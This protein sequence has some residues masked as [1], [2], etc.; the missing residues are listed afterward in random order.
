VNSLVEREIR[1]HSVDPVIDQDV[2]ENVLWD[3]RLKSLCEPFVCCV[4]FLQ[5]GDG[6]AP[7]LVAEEN[8]VQGVK[9]ERP[10]GVDKLWVG[11]WRVNRRCVAE[12]GIVG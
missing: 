2:S 9:H 3:M 4:E 1:I 8:Q 12:E 11:R 7:F 10:V 5:A 6:F